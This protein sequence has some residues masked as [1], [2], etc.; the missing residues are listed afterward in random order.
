[1]SRIPLRFRLP[2][3]VAGTVVPALVF[4]AALVYGNY[5]RERNAAFDRVLDTARTV[6][7]VMDRQLLA[8]TSALQILAL[9]QSLQQDDLASFR[10]DA[11]AFVA[12]YPDS[13]IVLAD[14]SGREILNSS[15]P[16]GSPPAMRNPVNIERVFTT[17]APAYSD[18][19]TGSVSRT[20]IMTIAVPVLHK[21]A[22]AEAIGFRLPIDT[23]Q[24]II[25]AQSPSADWTISLFDRSGTNFARTPNPEETV[26]QRASE[27]L[28]PELF[29]QPEAKL[30]TVSLEGAELITA[31]TRSDLTGWTVAAGLPTAVVTA[32]LRSSLGITAVV[33]AILTSV[34]IIFAVGMARS[35][36]RGEAMQELLLAEVNHRVKNTLS[37][38]QSIVYQTFRGTPDPAEAQRKIDGRLMALARTHQILSDQ[39]WQKTRMREITQAI[40]EPYLAERGGRIAMD[41]PDVTLSPRAALLLSMILHELATN[42]VKYG[43]LSNDAGKVSVSWSTDSGGERLKLTWEER[44]GPRVAAPDQKGL[45]SRLIEQALSQQLGG[46]ATVQYPPSGII[47]T[48]DCPTQ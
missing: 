29:K 35:I 17:G 39:S 8:L 11:D 46:S 4:C 10:R 32:P 36:A 22:V 7:F 28:Y 14:R 2:L 9:S 31:F 37:T 6:R 40:M 16:S 42:A 27:S 20:P 5:V 30:T 26:G 21:N 24:R 38:V 44:G 34:G 47:C 23:F 43:A 12:H 15:V 25:E 48:L 45:G 19:M 13:S 3:L 33:G 1:M 18:L 41:G